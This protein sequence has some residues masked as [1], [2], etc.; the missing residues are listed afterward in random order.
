[1]QQYCVAVFISMAM[2]PKLNSLD[3]STL[4]GTL[5]LLY[6]PHAQTQPGRPLARSA[7]ESQSHTPAPPAPSFVAVEVACACQKSVR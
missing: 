5:T 7:A 4:L 3:T 2:N 6:M 1:M